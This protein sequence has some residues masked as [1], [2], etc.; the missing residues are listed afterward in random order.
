[1]TLASVYT[2]WVDYSKPGQKPFKTVRGIQVTNLDTGKKSPF[3]EFT[4]TE[5]CHVWGHGDVPVAVIDC[6]RRH[7]TVND[8]ETLMGINCA[9]GGYRAKIV[10][11]RGT[12]E[13]VA[14]AEK[15]KD[16]IS[17][18]EPKAQEQSS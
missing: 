8:V 17:V 9:T 6:G 14:L 1:M 16:F 5:Y 11:R 10:A 13:A 3:Y 4:R 2:C 12:P 15:Y 18:E 7:F